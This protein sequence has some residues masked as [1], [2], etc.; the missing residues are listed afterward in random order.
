MA[1]E[2]GNMKELINFLINVPYVS[3]F[4]P[5]VAHTLL[6]LGQIPGQE[7]IEEKG[8]LDNIARALEG[9]DTILYRRNRVGQQVYSH[10]SEMMEDGDIFTIGGNYIAPFFR[11][12]NS[13]IN[14]WKNAGEETIEEINKKVAEEM[15]GY[16]EV[17]KAMPEGISYI[18]E[19]ERL[20]RLS[21]T[22]YDSETQS[23]ILGYLAEASGNPNLD[24]DLL[25]DEIGPLLPVG[26][27]RG[28]QLQRRNR[29]L[30]AALHEYLFERRLRGD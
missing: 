4:A 22:A 27:V 23:L 28:S 3:G 13:V 20:R 15:K 24:I 21:R 2:D 11:F 8:I 14:A 5:T 10:W 12:G 18:S 30:G 1:P 16:A 17:L 9:E 6:R 26:Y 29:S 19:T 25:K 7:K